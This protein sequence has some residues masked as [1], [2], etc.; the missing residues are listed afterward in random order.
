VFPNRHPPSPIPTDCGYRINAG[1]FGV[2]TSGNEQSG[3]EEQGYVTR[4]CF[5]YIRCTLDGPNVAPGLPI[6]DYIFYRCTQNEPSPGSAT[7]LS[8]EP[9]GA[10]CVKE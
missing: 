4:T 9:T 6:A 2:G 10:D 7:V 3:R 1:S 5:Y 8:F